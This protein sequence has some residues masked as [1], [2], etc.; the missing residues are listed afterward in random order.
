MTPREA[1]HDVLQDVDEEEEDEEEAGGA[2]LRTGGDADDGEVAKEEGLH[3]QEID[4][5][6][7]QRQI[8]RSYGDNIDAD[9]SQRLAELVFET[10]QVRGKTLQSADLRQLST[11]VP[12]GLWGAFGLAKANPGVLKL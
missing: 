11:G 3:P 8:T 2:E 6:W 10:L 12:W 9:E 7:L 1:V 5:Y 4:A